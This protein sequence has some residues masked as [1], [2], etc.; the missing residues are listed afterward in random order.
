[1]IPKILSWEQY[2]LHA[3][4]KINHNL[5]YRL[6]S[7][8]ES[9]VL[10]KKCISN[11]GQPAKKNLLEDVI[12]NYNYYCRYLIDYNQIKFKNDNLKLF[13]NWIESYKLTK[14]KLNL[15][16]IND[17]S[18][19]LIKKKA[20][21][22]NK[23]FIYGFTTLTPEQS[24][25]FEAIEHKTIKCSQTNNRIINKTFETNTNEILAAANWAKK[26]AQEKPK[27]NIAIIVP[28]L[29]ENYNQIKTIFDKVF[30]DNLNETKE[31][32]Y[33]ISLGL[34]LTSYPL[35]QHLL[36]TL[37]L[38]EQLQNNK[39]NTTIFN[40][41]VT[42]PYIAKAKTELS[43]RALLVNKILSLT[44]TNFK[45]EQ[46]EK[47]IEKTPL[48][49]KLIKKVVAKKL[50]TKKKHAEWLLSFNDCL[51]L[52]GFTTDRVLSS[53]EYQL[54]NKYQK[55]SLCLNVLSQYNEKVSFNQAIIDLTEWLSKVVFQA[56]SGKQSIQ[57]LGVTKYIH[58]DATWV[59][60]MTDDFLPPKFNSLNFIPYEIAAKNKITCSS[61]ELIK[62]DANETL[63]CL[64]N[65]SKEVIFSYAKNCFD[66]Q[67]KS[68]TLIQFEAKI[69]KIEDSAPIKLKLETI[70]DANAP[71]LTHKKINNGINT[72]KDQMSC[73]FKGFAHRLKLNDFCPPYI[74]LNRAEQGNIIHKILEKIYQNIKSLEELKS[75][76]KSELTTL[77]ESIIKEQLKFYEKSRF[78]QIEKQRI[79]KIIDKFIE[80][81]K[82]REEF[83]VIATEKKVTV[84]INN[85]IFDTKID[86]IDE[87]QE[88]LI[89]FD[90]KT[91]NIPTNP[92][93]S[94]P[95]KDPQLPIYVLT[96]QAS[97]IAIIKLL[98]TTD[99][100]EYIGL[101]KDENLVVHEKS[102]IKASQDWSYQ[103]NIWKKN[104]NEA[105][106]DYQKGVAEVLPT[107]QACT[108]C[109]LNSL[110]RI[111]E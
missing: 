22:T 63:E 36:L 82:D 111:K 28:K 96:N 37:Q 49:K 2:L 58:F 7:E 98:T 1:M 53:S 40:T 74:G 51:E 47:Y 27:K 35:I 64:V 97:G 65:L 30:N 100:I 87:V 109:K 41:V 68:S 60:G 15:I 14:S 83:K 94:N 42:S 55:T 6:I 90:Y 67:Q 86:R 23:T 32:N 46:I 91:G 43:D 50:N 20:Y 75:Y 92:W 101:C 13:I 77:I 110:C 57:I 44:Q 4:H 29:K 21:I 45:L 38:S 88:S 69:E 79:T 18:G 62:K 17:L 78:F 99:N 107:S 105:I 93:N 34:K 54:I 39:I 104:I 108:Y 71:K 81:E 84:N 61:F 80:S 16:D 25:L 52:W 24:K 106:L 70:K 5:K 72:L 95:I 8:I 11:S 26:L 48:L 73:A 59:L 66:K 85:L 10:I 89:I 76:K 31:K 103:I 12:K 56:N 3:W 102:K 33:G 9:S 19:I